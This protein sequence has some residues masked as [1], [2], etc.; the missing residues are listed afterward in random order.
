MEIIACR[1]NQTRRPQDYGRLCQARVLLN[2][3]FAN[4]LSCDVG[5]VARVVYR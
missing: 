4:I 1:P 2:C 5:I 3:S